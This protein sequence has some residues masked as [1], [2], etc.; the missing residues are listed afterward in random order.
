MTTTA[1]T[2]SL[3]GLLPS[4]DYKW[5]VKTICKANTST[6][7]GWSFT[8]SFTTGGF[9]LIKTGHES[10]P[11]LTLFPNP[12]TTII[13]IQLHGMKDKNIQVIL[14]DL[15]GRTLKSCTFAGDD[16]ITTKQMDVADLASGSY[17]IAVTGDQT[18][19]VERFVKQ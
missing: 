10:A 14:Y 3:T 2:L 5:R 19:M 1:T 11:S 9:R 15:V 18:K 16:G 8:K 6:S 17:L 12:V 4:T 13:S 7:S